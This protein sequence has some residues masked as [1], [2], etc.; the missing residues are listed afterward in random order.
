[1]RINDLEKELEL[2]SEKMRVIRKKFYE[3]EREKAEK[4][5]QV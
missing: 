5:K 3:M 1:M 4:Y 2:E